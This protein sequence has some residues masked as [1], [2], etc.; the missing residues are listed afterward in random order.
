MAIMPISALSPG[1]EPS[2]HY[3]TVVAAWGDLLEEDL[4]YGYFH[5]G[6]E[7]LVEA[8]NELTN[9]MLNLAELRSGLHV[10]D[11]GC[12]TGK[13]GCRMAGEYAARVTGISPSNA[14]VESAQLLAAGSG[15]QELAIFCHGDGTSMSF[16]DNSFDRVWLMESSHL[17]QDKKA[18]ISECA[19]VVRPGGRVVLCDIIVKRKLALEEVIQYRDEFLL[20]R[21]V[22]GRAIMEPLQFYRQQFESKGFSVAAESDISAPTYQ[23]FTRWRQNAN[24]NRESVCSKIGERAWEQF[25]LSCDVLEQFWQNNILGYGIICAVKNV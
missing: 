14:C 10:L 11:V 21:D 16:D 24:Q 22:F 20:L 1:S 12:G 15:Q 9:Q 4:H 6:T 13:A 2:Q 17:M 3:D 5:S 7:S 19:R 23:T 8:T 18:L 25:V